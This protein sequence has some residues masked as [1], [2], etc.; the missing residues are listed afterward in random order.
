MLTRL[1]VDGFKNL[2]DVAIDFDILTCITGPN[3]SGKSNVLDVIEFLSLLA[4]H[5]IQDAAEGIRGGSGHSGGP[6]HLLRRI[7]AGGPSTSAKYRPMRLA[8]EMILPSVALDEFGQ[9]TEPTVAFVRYEIELVYRHTDG[10]LAVEREALLPIKRSYAQ[11]RLRLLNQHDGFLKAVMRQGGQRTR[12]MPFIST[13]DEDGEPHVSVHRDRIRAALEVRADPMPNTAVK[14]V[15]GSDYP[16]VLA[17][18]REM[19]SWCR[20]ALDPA[21][22]SK[23]DTY[24]V[25][26]RINHGVDT[27][28]IAREGGRLAA[29]LYASA[30]A[31]GQP[32]RVYG[33]VGDRL[34][35]LVGAAA[36]CVFVEDDDLR[37]RLTLM[38]EDPHGGQHPVRTLSDGILQFL[39]LC[40]LPEIALTSSL[41]CIEHPENGIHPG[42]AKAVADVLKELAVDPRAALGP[43]NPLNQVVITT[44]SGSLCRTLE[45]DGASLVRVQDGQIGTEIRA[46]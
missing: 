6:L 5:P 40:V 2:R 45:Q 7:E 39:A 42:N 24:E 20:L 11:V 12:G 26:A 13:D 38:I 9:A 10:R 17:A 32:A 33:R 29:L 46:A 1:E 8:A 34:S 15:R 44:H 43:T 41:H 22:I 23:P 31:S 30:A 19:Q 3:C 27:L 36:R 4:S 18:R 14:A 37:H 21:A 16:T 28:P 25:L 35:T